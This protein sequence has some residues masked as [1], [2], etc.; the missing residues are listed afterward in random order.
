MEPSF[1]KCA[2]CRF[3]YES[4]LDMGGVWNTGILCYHTLE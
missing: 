2:H 4:F 1:V 3:I